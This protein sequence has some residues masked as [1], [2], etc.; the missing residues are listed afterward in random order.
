LLHQCGVEG[1][2]YQTGHRGDADVPGDV[3]L[4]FRFRNAKPA[5]CAR[6]EIARVICDD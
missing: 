2:R 5:Q 4:A 3:A 1:V 6:Y